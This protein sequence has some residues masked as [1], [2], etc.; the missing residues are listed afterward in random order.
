MSLEHVF[1]KYISA[2]SLAKAIFFRQLI[3]QLTNE[4]RSQ[5]LSSITDMIVTSLF[6]HLSK[7]NQITELNHV[8]NSLSGIIQSRKDKPKPISRRNIKL[9]Q[10]PMAI[11]GHT[12][13]FLNMWDYIDFSMSNRSIY[14]G[15]NL[16]SNQLQELYLEDVDNYITNFTS[17]S[18]VKT[19]CVNPSKIILP[20][21]HSPI[22]NQVTKLFLRADFKCDW[23]HPFLNQNIVNCK[24][25]TTLE[26]CQFGSEEQKMTKNE[27][28]SL[29]ERFP[30]VT[31]FYLRRIH[32]AD[33]VTAQDIVNTCPKVVKMYVV[34]DDIYLSNGLVHA[35]ASVLQHLGLFTISKHSLVWLDKVAFKNLEELC[36]YCPFNPLFM[37]IVKTA[38]HLKKIHVWY[39]M[40]TSN[41][42]LSNEDIKPSIE[43]LMVKCPFLTFM[44]F[45]VSNKCSNIFPYILDG[46]E[47]GLFKNKKQSKKQ[48]KICIHVADLEFKAN[49]FILNVGRI[50]KA[51]EAST[52]NDF[53]FIWKLHPETNDDQLSQVFKNL[54]ELN[55]H[56]KIFQV[57]N[58]FIVTNENCKI[59]GYREYHCMFTV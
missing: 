8:N 53:M 16:P 19:L 29:L 38:L 4:E 12:A 24:N 1:K 3:V 36:I 58:R 6:E 26:C 18:S 27:F 42:P 56:S 46:I 32:V 22:F 7:P 43:D 23:V 9:D 59:N 31:R 2:M 21:H 54:C 14:L 39:M 41:I 10:F 52:L 13:A 17:F 20:Q 50:V 5:F 48:L 34:I 57:D 47:C 37:N 30:N 49:D 51:L 25:V 35:F 15:C 33:D 55:V 40:D 28:L 11:I 44:L 45:K